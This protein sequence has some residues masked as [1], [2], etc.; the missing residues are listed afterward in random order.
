[1]GVE[2]GR[3]GGRKGKGSEMKGMERERNGTEWNGIDKNLK[4]LKGREGNRKGCDGIGK[5]ER[6]GKG[7][8]DM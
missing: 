8:G 4:E 7:Y 5:K 1:M 3:V 6:E 2:K